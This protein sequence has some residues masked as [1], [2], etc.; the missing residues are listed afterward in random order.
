VN[1]N[2]FCREHLPGRDHYLKLVFL[3]YRI[4]DGSAVDRELLFVKIT[5]VVFV[6]FENCGP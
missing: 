2:F 1:F 5:Q 3:E 4:F 6:G